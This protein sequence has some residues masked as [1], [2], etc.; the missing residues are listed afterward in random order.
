MRK[1]C[2]FVCPEKKQAFSADRTC[3]LAKNLHEQ[4][5]EM[6]KDFVA[7]FLAMPDKSDTAQLAVL[8]GA[9][10]NLYVREE[11]LGLNSLHGTTTGD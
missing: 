7:F 10:S 9:E 2:D 6:G 3:D 1:V 8:S 5:M 11:P 4:L